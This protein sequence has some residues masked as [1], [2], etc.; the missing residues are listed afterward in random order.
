[1]R[2]TNRPS[3]GFTAIVP[4]GTSSSLNQ[5]DTRPRSTR[6]TVTFGRRSLSGALDSE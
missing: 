5:F 1:L 4:P 6:F 2:S 3:G